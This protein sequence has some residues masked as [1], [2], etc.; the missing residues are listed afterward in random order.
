M[1][2]RM[3]LLFLVAVGLVACNRDSFGAQRNQEG[4]LDITVSATEAEVNTLIQT[5]LTQS[6][7]PLVRNP[8]VDLQDGQIVISGEHD[9]RDGSGQRV[10]GTITVVPSVLDGRLAVQVTSV[11]I[12][13]WDASDARVQEINQ[14]IEQ[15]LQ[16]RAVQDNPNVDLTRV[17]V[18]ND[19][20]TFTISTRPAQN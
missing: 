4:G 15:A 10:N 14:K 13:G 19:N 12:E 16:G 6:A 20:L 9:K 7:N 11:N 17:M 1:F 3:M 5:A 18:S 2:T 8:S